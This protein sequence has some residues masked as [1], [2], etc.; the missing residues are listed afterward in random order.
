MKLGKQEI[1]R[2][3]QKLEHVEI[4]CELEKHRRMEALRQEHAE[5]LKY[6]RFQWERERERADGWLEE[7]KSRFELEK[8]QY[9]I[10]I[11][12]LE[13]ELALAK[14]G[15]SP[16]REL[17][18]QHSCEE[19]GPGRHVHPETLP[20]PQ[21]GT[22]QFC[23]ESRGPAFVPCQEHNDVIQHQSLVD[24]SC[25]P[26][27]GNVE[28]QP[29]VG[30][31]NLVQLHN[32][33]T[34]SLDSIA[35]TEQLQHL[36]I[37]C[38]QRQVPVSIANSSANAMA[39]TNANVNNY[40]G[41]GGN[42]DHDISAAS[43]V[44]H[45]TTTATTNVTGNNPVMA[46]GTV[47][48]LGPP[49]LLP[50][51]E[52][53]ST[54]QSDL[55]ESMTKLLQAQTQMLAAQAQAVAVQTLPPLTL[56]NGEESQNEDN[57]FDRW[58]ERFEERAR[59]AKW[60]DEQ[61][62]CQLKAHLE[63][64]A[65]QVFEIMAA[66]EKSS[67]LK[68]VKALQQRFKPVDIEE[69]RGFEFHQLMQEQQTVE[70]LGIELQRLGRKAFPN[71]DSKEFD[72]MLKGRF[73]PALHPKWQRKVGAPKTSETF[74]ELYDRAR[75]IERQERQISASA[76]ARGDSKAPTDRPPAKQQQVANRPIKTQNAPLNSTSTPRSTMQ[77]Q[78][79]TQESEQ[80]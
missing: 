36:D 16:E 61:K 49:P 60:Q 29:M 77:L 70:Q 7:V 10:R 42:V 73:F 38:V 55:I 50:M 12:S 8:M 74:N 54:T 75:T 28:L 5:Q 80:H 44:G 59:L 43:N 9:E 66:D 79:S 25:N 53:A 26:V 41:R 56:Y 18:Y 30:R 34:Q 64:T 78:A 14:R 24:N 35:D 72:R 37:K 68:A 71:A 46:T 57:T 20:R 63:K 19:G 6:E 58:M 51:D 2:L 33:F 39:N 23:L 45:T 76:A 17:E 21:L 3:A 65:L 1:Q 67:Y 15:Y 52:N 31:Q 11:Q 4:H 13:S 40:I 48:A 47:Q 69:L 32:M 62:L 27:S 22:K